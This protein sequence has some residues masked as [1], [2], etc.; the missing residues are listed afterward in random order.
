M[1]NLTKKLLELGVI[2]F[3]LQIVVAVEIAAIIL[4]LY[5]LKGISIVGGIAVSVPIGLP[6]LVVQATLY[7]ICRSYRQKFKG[8]DNDVASN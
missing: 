7:L 6:L 8:K 5:Y 3:V 4:Y 2:Y 1:S